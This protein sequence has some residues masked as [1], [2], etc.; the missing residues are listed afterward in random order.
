MNK[1]FHNFN[2]L[3][4]FGLSILVISYLISIPFG[5]VDKKDR[6]ISPTELGL[7]AIIFLLNSDLIERITKFKFNNEGIDVELVERKQTAN[8]IVN[9]K[10]IR[11]LVFLG[12]TQ[13][14]NEVKDKKLKDFFSLLL[15]DGDRKIL[16][17]FQDP[18]NNSN[19]LIYKKSD[20]KLLLSVTHLHL[21]GFLETE[22][23][24]SASK[25]ASKNYSINHDEN[26]PL[27]NLEENAKLTDVFRL[28]ETGK[29]CLKYTS[30]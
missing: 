12:E 2:S 7:I 25:I 13:L 9:Q 20:E 16:E 4:K 29:K 8:L 26:F 22:Y 24:L 18:A 21:L 1:F 28:S 19:E 11:A 6:R 14:E 23:E 17:K 15:N 3:I 10:E 30:D 5:L 27:D